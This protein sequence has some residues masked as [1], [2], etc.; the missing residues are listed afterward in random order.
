M[1]EIAVDRIQVGKELERCP[2]PIPMGWYVVDLSDTLAV[3]EVRTVFAFDQEWV[4]F[5]GEDGGVGISDPFCPHLGAHL[6]HGGTVQGNHLR[7]P[8][9]HWE[10]DAGGWC[11]HIPYARSLP[12]L[13][14][15]QAVLRTLPVEERYGLI[16][17]WYH[18]DAAAPAW[19]IPE[20]PEMMAEGY[21]PVRHG[22]WEISTCI[23]EIAENGV[24]YP[25]L[26][27]L[28]GAP[29]IPPGTVSTE[30]P[31]L[32]FDI[33]E[34]YIVGDNHGPGINIVRH[35]QGDVTVLMFSTPLPV[36]RE[37]TL[38]RMHFTFPDFR[39]GTPERELAEHVY[40]HSIGQAEGEDSA[41][42]EAV[43]MLIWNNKK[44]RPRPLLCDGDG[45]IFRF[46]K[47]FSQF[48]AE[49]VEL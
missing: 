19:P 36:T 21:V 35:T 34:G 47:W 38:S 7:C 5:R 27:F 28:H 3:G 42:F 48:Y 37:L 20:V 32:H 30:G 23:Q 11:K 8:F 44:Y 24:D 16:W 49:P 18:P 25:H 14:Q 2:F 10:Y 43:D 46:R 29:E 26:K 33:G 41:G 17:A 4:M 39:P 1:N 9:H 40:Q 31:V 22:E 12:P 15:K 45:P 13:A 6:G